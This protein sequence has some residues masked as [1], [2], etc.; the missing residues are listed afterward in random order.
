MARL[1]VRT[2]LDPDEPGVPAAVLVV[3]PG[4]TPGERAVALLGVHCHGADGWACL[5]RTDGWAEHTRDGEGL[6]V[7]VVAYP[8]VLRAVDVDPAGFPGRSAADGEAVVILRVRTADVP[9]AAVPLSEGTAV[10]TT[11]SDA[12]LD[13]VIAA[14]DDWPMVLASPPAAVTGGARPAGTRAAPHPAHGAPG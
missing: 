5:A 3:D 12:P 10:W 8:R 14:C 4:G 7:A 9:G 1:Y 2:G 6:E 11:G 13:E